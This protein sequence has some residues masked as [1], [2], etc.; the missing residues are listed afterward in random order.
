MKTCVKKCNQLTIRNSETE[1]LVTTKLLLSEPTPA[2]L[3]LLTR[4]LGLLC[5]IVLAPFLFRVLPVAGAA[6]ISF[7]LGLMIALP[8]MVLA[9]VQRGLVLRAHTMQSQLRRLKQPA[10][11]RVVWR[12]L[13]GTGLAAVLLVRLAGG[14]GVV[15]IITLSAVPATLV[16]LHWLAPIARAE[17]RGVHAEVRLRIW[18]QLTA[19]AA[20][21]L[22][23]VLIS[24]LWAAP[25]PAYSPSANSALVTEGL[26][27]QRLWSGIEAALLGDAVALGRLPDW[28]SGVLLVLG[29]IASAFA[30]SALTLAAQI[31]PN[32]A[33][34]AFAP[35]SDAV[36][37]PET[38]TPALATLAVL[39]TVWLAAAIWT[40][41]RLV[42]LPIEL[43]PVSQF[44]QAVEIVGENFYRPGTYAE[45][46]RIAS[47]MA[48]ADS[49]AVFELR[50]ALDVGFDVM[51][52]NV[53]PFLD[54]YYSLNAEYLRIFDFFRDLSSRPFGGSAD[55]LAERIDA[56]LAE[57]LSANAPFAAYDVLVD[58]VSAAE[59]QLSERLLMRDRVV[60]TNP[61]LVRVDATFDAF[62]PMPSFTAPPLITLLETRVGISVS[63]GVLTAMIAQRVGQRLAARGVLSF[64]ARGLLTAVP[65]VGIATAVGTDV[66]MLKI[67]ESLNRE[68]FRAE[69]VNAIEE[70]RSK[71]HAV[72]EN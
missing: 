55:Y 31:S 12:V 44:Q 4:V 56:Q 10:V 61:A 63:S 60:N 25:N 1:K 17:Y 26:A 27:M 71:A 54:A 7:G 8:G 59:V 22:M 70:Q 5:C 67:E 48:E 37:R 24:L 2:S 65:F 58:A 40:E 32:V 18:A 51:I 19:T 11:L 62:P 38:S 16:A 23:A 6:I 30:M 57:S 15:W 53:D 43:R 50:N 46:V 69:I 45:S 36:S 39:F 33:K 52:E 3:P 34:R 35:A 41:K 49:S 14:D 68:D 13:I 72:F 29:L 9:A 42:S 64:A 28:F 20:V 47:A 66:V 21:C